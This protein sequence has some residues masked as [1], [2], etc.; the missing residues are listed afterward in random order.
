MGIPVGT[1]LDPLGGSSL[2]L[3]TG[4][5]VWLVA[6]WGAVPTDVT[7]AVQPSALLAR[8][9][10]VFGRIV[11]TGTVAGGI[12]G[13]ILLVLAS[14]MKTAADPDGIPLDYVLVYAGVGLAVSVWLC[15]A[16][17]AVA[18]FNHTAWGEF[19]LTRH[20]LARR[21]LVPHDLMAFLADA[22]EQ[23]GV[24][25]QVGPSYQFRHIELQHQLAARYSTLLPASR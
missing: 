25:R 9:R 12:L 22:H 8:D 4:L 6:G 20:H 15:P 11:C 7:T 1:F 5:I 3:A 17:A 21:R 19:V 23:H 10:R 13:L 18:A 14:I 24:L 2:G 16:L